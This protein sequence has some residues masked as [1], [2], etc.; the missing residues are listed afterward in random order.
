MTFKN[1]ETLVRVIQLAVTVAAVVISSYLTLKIQVSSMRTELQMFREQT[2][3]SLDR[4]EA[5]I[6]SLNDLTHM[7]DTRLTRLETR[8]DEG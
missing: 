5:Q 3:R 1:S 2:E 8:V 7:L 6:R 4:I